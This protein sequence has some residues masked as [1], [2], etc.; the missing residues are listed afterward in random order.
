[1]TVVEKLLTAKNLCEMGFGRDKAY[2]L[3]HNSTFPAIKI[4]GRY[5]VTETA[6][7]EW[8]KR[9]QYKTVIL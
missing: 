8:M 5:Y 3:M 2:Q 6:L 7:Q 1:M 4:G 9:H